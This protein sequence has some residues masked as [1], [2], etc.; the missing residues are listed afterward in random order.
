MEYRGDNSI[1]NQKEALKEIK[2]EHDRYLYENPG[3]NNNHYRGI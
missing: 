1:G 3:M 2:I